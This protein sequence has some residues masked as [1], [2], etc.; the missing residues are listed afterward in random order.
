MDTTI[1]EFQ[2]VLVFFFETKPETKKFFNSGK[3]SRFDQ[4]KILIKFIY[5]HFRKFIE[6]NF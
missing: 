4:G 5:K 6:K 1:Y 3:I 2:E